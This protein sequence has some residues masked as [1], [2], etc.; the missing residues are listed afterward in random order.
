MIMA[1][2]EESHNAAHRE[3]VVR[4]D[5]HCHSDASDGYYAPALVADFLADAGVA[6]AAL[7][8]HQPVAGL[9]PFHETAIGHGIVEFAGVELHAML[10]GTEIHLLTYGFNP[11]S[12]ALQPLLTATPPAAEAI[13]V[14]TPEGEPVGMVSDHD[15][16]KRVVAVGLDTQLPVS[17]IMSAPLVTIDEKAPLFEAF[18]LERERNVRHL[19]VL[20]SSGALVGIIQSS[21]ALQPDRYS[22]MAFTHRIRRAQRIGELV[23]S[24]RDLPALVGALVE[25]GALPQNL[26]H[27]TTSVSDAITERVIALALEQLGTPPVPFAFVALGSEARQEQTL[28]TDQ[29]NALIYADPPPDAPDKVGYDF[30]VAG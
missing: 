29:D 19:A 7:T 9:L 30:R 2:G 23:E 20:D 28:A 4:V 16:R 8:D 18:L 21:R 3:P 6:Y 25:S 12:P 15:L 22:L 17:R 1:T 27:V 14:T 5:L 10:D 13:A 24:Y 26:C 11:A